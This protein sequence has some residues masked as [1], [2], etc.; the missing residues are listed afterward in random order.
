M[1]FGPMARSTVSLRGI[2]FT[3]SRG[4]LKILEALI[5]I[6]LHFHASDLEPIARNTA[7]GPQIICVTTHTDLPS[8]IE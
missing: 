3:P 5:R 7:P 8:T 2:L 1:A 4:N 6:G